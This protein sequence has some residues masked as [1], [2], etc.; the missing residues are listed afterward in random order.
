MRRGPILRGFGRSVGM[1]QAVQRS[2]FRSPYA[3]SGRLL[4]LVSIAV[5]LCRA[6]GL[7]VS[8]KYLRSRGKLQ[9]RGAG[10]PVLGDG[11]IAA[12]EASSGAAALS[13]GRVAAL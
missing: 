11:R 5:G 3:A 10:R 12:D 9:T 13:H 4:F 8:R 1:S 2:R 7:Q 6:S